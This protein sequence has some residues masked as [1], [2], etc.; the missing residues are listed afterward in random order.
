[1]TFNSPITDLLNYR[2]FN[3]NKLL[4]QYTGETDIITINED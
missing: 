3:N 2:D 4:I 1:M